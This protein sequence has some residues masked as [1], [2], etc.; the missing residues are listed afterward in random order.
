MPDRTKIDAGCGCTELIQRGSGG[1]F[2][3]SGDY[4]G[5]TCERAQAIGLSQGDKS[6]AG[7]DQ[8]GGKR[9]AIA[10]EGGIERH[11]FACSGNA[12]GD[13]VG[14]P[15]IVT[16]GQGVEWRPGPRGTRCQDKSGP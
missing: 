15:A 1:A 9:L 7:G 16:R 13:S 4:R 14:D 8:I 2:G 11:E 3:T 5:E 12:H 6:D 10:C